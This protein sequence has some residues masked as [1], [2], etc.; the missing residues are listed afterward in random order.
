MPGPALG[1]AVERAADMLLKNETR[2]IRHVHS[3]GTNSSRDSVEM[4]GFRPGHSSQTP[5]E[6]SVPLASVRYDGG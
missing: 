6:V 1:A 5:P 2:P 4:V 3:T